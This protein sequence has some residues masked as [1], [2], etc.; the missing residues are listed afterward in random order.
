MV[1]QMGHQTVMFEID[2]MILKQAIPSEEYDLSKLGALF[3]KINFQMRVGLNVLQTL[4]VH[5]GFMGSGCIE[6]WLSQF[7]E[8]VS[9]IV[10]GDMPSAM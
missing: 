7:S 9:D 5:G 1:T 8:F 10:D 2:S 6:T 3:R 4:V